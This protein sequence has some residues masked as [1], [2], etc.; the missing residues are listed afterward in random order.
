MFRKLRYRIFSWTPH[1]ELTP[2][3]EPID[4]IIPIVAK[5]LQTLPLCL[6]GV[7]RQVQNTIKDIY[8]VAPQNAEITDFCARNGLIYV[9]EA[10]V[11]GYS[12]RQL[13]LKVLPPNAA[14]DADAKPLDRS[15][16]LF[17][18]F[19]K[20]SGAIGTCR[21][22]LCIDADHILI[23]PHV[24][25]ADSGET[26]LYMS[27]E[28]HQPYYDIIR[29]MLPNLPLAPLS[30]VAHKMLFDKELLQELQE[31]L[32]SVTPNSQCSTCNEH[33]HGDVGVLARDQKGL[34][35]LNHQPSPPLGKLEEVNSSLFTLHSSLP[36]WQLA[37]LHNLDRSEI[38][39]FSEFE[40][41][42]NFAVARRLPI[43]R[44][45]QQKRLKRK[46]IADYDTLCRKYAQPYRWTLTFP[47]Y[48]K[49][50]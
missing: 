3:T 50:S 19:V 41:Y 32:S 37:I 17:Q 31:E 1:P 23:H 8:I 25:L 4:V 46:Y 30:F 39:G 27:Y 5:D 15:G 16:W 40:T 48:M 43:L 42:G 33:P 13:G 2:S 14:K 11:F 22:Y 21:H 38:S 49:Q 20:L 45:W 6:Q 12:P 9:D 36:S 28:N 18:Q 35:S 34:T 26:V 47:D 10:S 29:R 7:R 24:F 44:P